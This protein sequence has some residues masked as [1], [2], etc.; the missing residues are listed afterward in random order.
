LTA[1]DLPGFTISSE[2][3]AD[4][5]HE[6]QLEGQMRRCAGPSGSGDG[7][8][9]ESSKRFVLKRSILRLGVS[10][11]VGVARTPTVAARELSAMRSARVRGCFSHYL[12][13]LFGALR[14]AGTTVGPV[15]IESGTPP[16]PGAAGGF[17]WRVKAVLRIDRLMLPFYMDLLSFTYGPARVVLFSSGVLRPF[18]AEIQQ[19]LFSLLLTRAEA[20]KL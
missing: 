19:R 13:L 5:P 18:P 4:T 2:P 3:E 9:E 16:T 14:G 12:G 10:S 20:R 6:K 15:S 17:A 8:A 1:A 7:L 11:E